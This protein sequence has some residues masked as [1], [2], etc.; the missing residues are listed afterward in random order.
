MWFAGEG[1]PSGVYVLRIRVARDL[2]V[3]FGRFAGGALLDVPAGAYAYVGSALASSGSTSLLPRLLRHVTR[4]GA[5][6]PHAIRTQ[7]LRACAGI[8][9]PGAT[10]PRR[11]TL[12]WNIDYLLDEEDAQVVGVLA[13]RTTRR[14]EPA[15]ARLLLAQPGV[16]P[17]ARGL[18]AHDTRDAGHVLH[19]PGGEEWWMAL[20]TYIVRCPETSWID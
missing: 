5:R 7:V 6:P 11:K 16:S 13:I 1:C 12:F 18:G 8:G 19:I 4:S 3:A 10:P 15:L 14:L 9:M 2:R 17:L 20:T